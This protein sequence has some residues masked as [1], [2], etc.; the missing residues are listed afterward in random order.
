MRLRPQLLSG[1]GPSAVGGLVWEHLWATSLA[2]VLPTVLG[3]GRA[4][5]APLQPF[6][7]FPH[8][9]FSPKVGGPDLFCSSG[10]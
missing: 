7:A 9:F 8:P 2:L 10:K 1:A 4:R 3:G 6:L 5:P